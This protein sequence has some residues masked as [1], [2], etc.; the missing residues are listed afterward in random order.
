[1][2]STWLAVALASAA[3][4]AVLIS[5]AWSRETNERLAAKFPPYR[6]VKERHT[7]HDGSEVVTLDCG[8]R[9]RL[10]FNRRQSLPCQ[11]C[12]EERK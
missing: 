12:H 9:L 10:T 11:C 3:L 4:G 2:I 6:E 8:H 7:D 1:M 5:L